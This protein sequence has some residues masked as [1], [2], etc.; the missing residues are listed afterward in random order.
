MMLR[1]TIQA[2]LLSGTALGALLSMTF[3]AI[4]DDRIERVWATASPVQVYGTAP[5]NRTAGQG[6]PIQ[7]HNDASS[8]GEVWFLVDGQE[9]S[10]QPGDTLDLESDR[11]HL[12]EY[13]TGGDAGDVRFTLY[14]G[15]YKFKVSS[16]GW[17]LFKSSDPPIASRTP[18]AQ[19]PSRS[20]GAF[21][22]P[23]PAMDLRSRRTAGRT[24]AAPPPAAPKAGATPAP[25]SAGIGRSQNSDSGVA[26]PPAPGVIRQRTAAPKTP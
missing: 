14:Q 1:R 9:R 10:L 5:T 3:T 12:V 13:N 4:G 8:G 25:P 6:A 26:T 15:L 7:L 21:T 2:T 22:P 17:G 19:V 24:E 20:Q 16:G 23:L 11:P 18:A